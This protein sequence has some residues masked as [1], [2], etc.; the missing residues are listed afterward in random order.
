MKGQGL[1]T[2]GG[3]SALLTWFCFMSHPKGPGPSWCPE[4]PQFDRPFLGFV[5]TN[6]SQNDHPVCT[7]VPGRTWT[8]LN[9][10]P[11]SIRSGGWRASVVGS[12]PPGPPPS[13]PDTGWWA[14]PQTAP[15]CASPRQEA[16]C[17]HRSPWSGGVTQF[18]TLLSGCP[19]DHPTLPIGFQTG[20]PLEGPG[21][22]SNKILHPVTAG[23]Q[24][25][26]LW[27]PR[28]RACSPFVRWCARPDR[29]KGPGER[30]T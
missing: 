6:T 29:A 25:A 3:Q 17:P 18:G 9:A 22:S 28:Q 27:A 14:S 10:R 8:R 13:V 15:A 23:F 7:E 1:L 5:R 4:W 20:H 12:P 2:S 30:P 19:M 26:V 24:T 11:R 16:G 21:I